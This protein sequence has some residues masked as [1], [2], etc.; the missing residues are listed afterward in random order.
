MQYKMHV[1][2][3]TEAMHVLGEELDVLY[4]HLSRMEKLS[5]R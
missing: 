2:W 5:F 3:N 1:S 4:M